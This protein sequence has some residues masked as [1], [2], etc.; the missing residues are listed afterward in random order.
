MFKSW[1]LQLWD[2]ECYAHGTVLLCNGTVACCSCGTVVYNHGTA[3]LCSRTVPCC[4]RGTVVLHS[5]DSLAV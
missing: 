4:S 5:W 2:S 3:L 1:V